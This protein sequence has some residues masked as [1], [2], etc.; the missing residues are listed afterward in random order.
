MAIGN[1]TAV[2]AIALFLLTA[3]VI[4]SS[5]FIEQEKLLPIGIWITRL[6][7]ILPG[8]LAIAIGIYLNVIETESTLGTAL[9]SAGLLLEFGGI[10][11]LMLILRIQ[12]GL[13]NERGQGS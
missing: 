6:T 3:N 9:F 13:S 4:I 12:T 10:Q 1:D 8:F 5:W 2:F 7:A 11:L